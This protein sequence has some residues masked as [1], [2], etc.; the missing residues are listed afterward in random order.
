MKRTLTLLLSLGLLSP[1]LFAAPEAALPPGASLVS[2][3]TWKSEKL[4]DSV[5]LAHND[6]A[7]GDFISI[8]QKEAQPSN[9]LLWSKNEPGIHTKCYAL[10]G[11][12]RYHDVVGVGY[13]NLWNEFAGPEVTSPKQTYFTR[14]LAEEGPLRKI[15]RSS[16]WRPF[17]VPF[18]ASQAKT[19]PTRLE[20]DLVL[21]GAG[22]VDLSDFD[23]LEF[24]DPGTMW[25]AMGVSAGA[26]AS[27]PLPWQGF[28]K[29]TLFGG[30]VIAL[31]LVG[32]FLW[33]RRRQSELRRM[34]AMDAG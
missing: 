15:T 13:L 19:Q 14:T 31:L 26:A 34:R 6:S 1:A 18:D 12:I 29:A 7:V 16:E 11:K 17:F 3:V 30:G 28:L 23:L 8:V 33:W 27:T 24:A 4:P 25:G 2:H 32:P 22:A 20:L 5:T 10:R 21:A 9:L